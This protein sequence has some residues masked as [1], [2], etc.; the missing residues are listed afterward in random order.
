MNL[1]DINAYWSAWAEEY[2]DRVGDEEIDRRVKAIQG[3]VD[4]EQARRRKDDARE[5]T[6]NEHKRHKIGVQMLEWSNKGAA[7]AGGHE[8]KA[9]QT[10][11]LRRGAGGTSTGPGPTET[12]EHPAIAAYKA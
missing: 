5:R 1:E 6:N 3:Q 12:Q 7:H 9:R 10:G 4:A 2:R 8:T 11:D